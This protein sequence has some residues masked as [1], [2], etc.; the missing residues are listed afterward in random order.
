MLYLYLDESGDLGFDFVN[1]K[2]SKFFTITILGING[3]DKNRL[4]LNAVKKTLRRKLN[5][6]GKRKRIVNELKG[7]KTVLEIKRYF[8]EQLRRLEFYIYAITLNKRRIYKYLMKEKARV[9]NF[10][11]RNIIDQIPFN[12]IGERVELIVD[13]SK[14][15]PEIVEFNDYIRRQMEARIDPKILLD[16]YHVNSVENGGLQAIDIFSYGIFEK[17][18]RKKYDWFNIFKE[19]VRYD[20]LYLPDKKERAV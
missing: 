12:D 20:S 2:P 19:K 9:Y 16:I 8:Y 4:L 15:K 11:G 5:P 1:K 10:I 13:R 17:Y 14:S 7:T 3:N 6:K 18:E